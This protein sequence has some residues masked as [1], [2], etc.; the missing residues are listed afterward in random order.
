MLIYRF[1]IA[2]ADGKDREDTGRM[3]L[4]DDNAARAFGKAIIKDMM[5]ESDPQRM[6]DERHDGRTL[7]LQHPVRRSCHHLM[8][9]QC[10]TSTRRSALIRR[11]L[12]LI[13]DAPSHP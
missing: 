1:S 6:D 7:Y 2:D 8:L 9:V 13:L 5:Q 3:V 11:K 10:D 12:V 4:S